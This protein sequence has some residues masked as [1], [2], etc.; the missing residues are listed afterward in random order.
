MIYLTAPFPLSP[1]TEELRAGTIELVRE[2]TTRDYLQRGITVFSPILY[3]PP[4]SSPS[5]PLWDDRWEKHNF[6]FLSVCTSLNILCLPYWQEDSI[7]QREIKKAQGWRY[8]IREILPDGLPGYE[9][10]LPLFPR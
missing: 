6:T 1:E 7:L 3:N 2:I 5:F 4:L 9:K 8:K 10:I